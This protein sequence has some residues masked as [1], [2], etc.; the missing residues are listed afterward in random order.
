[1]LSEFNI[2]HVALTTK[3]KKNLVKSKF[4][5]AMERQ[6]RV[7][8][9]IKSSD[10]ETMNGLVQLANN[11]VAQMNTTYNNC[12]N[13][14]K[15]SEIYRM[16]DVLSEDQSHPESDIDYARQHCNK[17]KQFAKDINYNFWPLRSLLDELIARLMLYY[18]DP[19][20]GAYSNAIWQMEECQDTLG[21]NG[22]ESTSSVCKPP[23]GPGKIECGLELKYLCFVSQH[24]IFM[25]I[26]VFKDPPKPVYEQS[27]KR[28]LTNLEDYNTAVNWSFAGQTLD[29]MEYADHYECQRNLDLYENTVLPN[30]TDFLSY[31]D[32]FSETPYLQESIDLYYDYQSIID[33]KIGPYLLVSDS[34]KRWTMPEN[35]GDRKEEEAYETD[36]LKCSWFGNLYESEI[37]EF[38]DY[39]QAIGQVVSTK[40][41]TLRNNFET[42]VLKMEKLLE[43]YKDEMTEPIQSVK[44]YLDGEIT[45]QELAQ[46][47]SDREFNR[48]II[49]LN[50]LNTN[51]IAAVKSFALS[52]KSLHP[53]LTPFYEMMMEKTFSFLSDQTKNNYPFLEQMMSWYNVLGGKEL[54]EKYLQMNGELQGVKLPTNT[55]F[56]ENNIWLAIE[57]AIEGF[58]EGATH[59]GLQALVSTFTD[60]ITNPVKDLIT[61]LDGMV[62]Q[63]REYKKKL[64]MNTDF[65]L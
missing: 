7:V 30:I 10:E 27:A 6:Q 18:E 11:V 21:L 64:K 51:L 65:Y 60:D 52:Y 17:L 45:K 46:L 29:A 32:D 33:T 9:A 3:A 40:H 1:M 12:W 57:Q 59:T 36:R 50:F 15:L 16:P 4:G 58:E 23:P 42:I 35:V 54:L 43:H 44:D 55:T 24:I 49:K 14:T 5:Q 38:R 34:E 56:T 25:E 61:R 31:L 22:N 53:L 28:V 48:A 26:Y 47:F 41:K 13:K 62:S 19:D 20:Y 63:M 8:K 39:L 37:K 2:D